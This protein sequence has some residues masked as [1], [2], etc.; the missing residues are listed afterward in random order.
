[1]A[2]GVDD[3]PRIVQRRLD[4]RDDVERVRRRLPVEQL[5]RGDRERRQRLV[6]GEV[7]LQVDRE[8]QRAALVVGRIDALHD[9]AGQQRL[10]D[11]VDLR[12]Q[13][14]LRLRRFAALAQQPLEGRPGVTGPGDDVEHHR[15]GDLHPRH[16]RLRRPG[17]QLLEGALPPR[18][19][20]LLRLL[21]LDALELLGVVAGLADEPGVLDLVLGRLHHDVPDRVVA[22]AARAAGDLLELAHLELA[23]TGPVVLRQPAEQHRPDG[24]VDA[25]AERVG[26]ADDLEQALLRQRL[27]E[28]PVPRQHPGMVHAHTHPDQPRQRLAERRREPEVAQRIGDDVAL[29][30]GRD[31]DAGQRLRALEGRD[32]GEVHDVDR[33]LSGLDELLERLLHRRRDVLADQRD[34]TLGRGDDRGVAAR[35]TGQVCLE[36]GRVAERR[37]HQQELRLGQL[38]QRHLPRPTPVGI[39]VEVELVHH[40]QADVGVGPLAQRHVGQDLGRGGDDR[41]VGVDRRVTGDHPDVLGTEDL[42]QVEE[43]LAD[44]RL[45]RCGVDA[46]LAAGEGRGHRA[47]RDQALARAGGGGEDDV[48]ARDALQDRL[49]LG[50]VHREAARL[51]PLGDGFVDRVLIGRDAFREQIDETHVPI[52]PCRGDT[53][54]RR[55]RRLR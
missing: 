36:L 12:E 34:R 52:V 14:V 19:E 4:D 25:D 54:G 26:A 39:G 53:P 46:A 11:L 9:P 47:G 55:P 38:D 27:D 33:R 20:A 7:G 31:L 42:A 2:L 23:L 49:V 51:D 44:Q 29:R 43:L 18:H 1:M 16:E 8:L 48:G 17:R 40:D 22:G 15:V 45:D 50:G 28:S 24:H 13:L 5:E 6:Q 37:R 41:R 30:T 35:A 10:D 32:L 3:R 21:A